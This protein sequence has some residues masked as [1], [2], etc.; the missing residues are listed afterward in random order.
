MLFI[1]GEVFGI[2]MFGVAGLLWMLVPFWD[3]KSSRGQQNRLVNYLGIFAVFYI[4]ILT[5]V[6]W[7][8]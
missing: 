7:L 3:Q 6:G 8:L 2:M 5:M 1:D 4:I